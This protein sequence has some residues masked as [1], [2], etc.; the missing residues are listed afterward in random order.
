[1][2]FR[3]DASLYYANADYL[4]DKIQE[5]LAKRKEI[6]MILIDGSS[7]NEMDTTAVATVC[8]LVDELRAKGVELYFSDLKSIVRWMFE[9]GNLYDKIGSDHFYSR[10]EDFMAAYDA[11]KFDSLSS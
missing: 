7:I 9:K 5:N 8:E 2:I 10:R 6:K 1:M 3:I 4:K 11:G